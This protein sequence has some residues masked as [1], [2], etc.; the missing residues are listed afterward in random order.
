MEV[1]LIY[2]VASLIQTLNFPNMF[3]KFILDHTGVVV[4]VARIS[5]S[6]LIN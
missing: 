2:N 3:K 1:C 5:S 6:Q 4:P